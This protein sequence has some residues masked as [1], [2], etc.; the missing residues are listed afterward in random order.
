M[1]RIHLI[2]DRTVTASD[3]TLCDVAMSE[4]IFYSL[5]GSLTDS[6]KYCVKRKKNFVYNIVLIS[7]QRS[8]TN[9]SRKDSESSLKVSFLISCFATVAN[10]MIFKGE[11]KS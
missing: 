2:L 3:N 4:T 6:E 5:L 1:L 9:T 7:A 10:Q 11:K 8:D